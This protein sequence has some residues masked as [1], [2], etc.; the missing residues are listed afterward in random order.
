MLQYYNILVILSGGDVNQ[1]FRGFL[2]QARTMADETP[3]GEF[4]IGSSTDQQNRC[5]DNVS[6]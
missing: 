1:D 4:M 6:V 3:V 2:M 5:M